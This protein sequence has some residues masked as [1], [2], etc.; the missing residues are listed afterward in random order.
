MLE[1]NDMT[2][3]P[4]K[5]DEDIQNLLNKLKVTQIP[6]YLSIESDPNST[7]Q[8]CFPIVQ[9]KVIDSGGKMVMGWQI[10]KA[11]YLVE[12]ECHA[13]WEDSEG[14]L[15][16]VTPKPPS[17]SKILFVKD[18]SLIYQEK[19]I[20]NVR[21]NITNNKLVDELVLVSEAI[22]S[23]DNK[24]ERAMLYGTDFL[25]SLTKA[26]MEYREELM[27]IHDLINILLINKGNRNSTCPCDSGNK[28]KHCH[29][30]DLSKKVLENV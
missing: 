4:E 20:D 22:F 3:T 9:K 18:E 13:V 15:H 8:D 25:K 27:L 11:D 28:Y 23:F 29:G 12:A 17:F 2:T 30:K 19:Q 7:L 26:Q 16:D 21:L 24:G 1:R 10:W 6:I 14:I 5:I